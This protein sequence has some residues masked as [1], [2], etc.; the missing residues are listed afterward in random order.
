MRAGAAAPPGPGARGGAPPSSS[1]RVA[2]SRPPAG[3]AQPGRC[4][5][6]LAVSAGHIAAAVVAVL[7]AAVVVWRRRE[8]ST[9]RTLVLL[10][11]AAA[12]GIYASGVLSLL[13]DPKDVIEDVAQALGP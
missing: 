9:E 4:P 2:H 3:P 8:F 12:L 13:P 7:I 5:T 11:I 10:L 6:L 1:P